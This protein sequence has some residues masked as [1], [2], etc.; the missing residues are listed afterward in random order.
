LELAEDPFRSSPLW[1]GDH[2]RRWLA[3]VALSAAIQA[4]ELSAEEQQ[5]LRDYD[6]GEI[7]YAKERGG[8]RPIT[9]RGL[10]REIVDLLFPNLFRSADFRA[11]D[12]P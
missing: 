4:R 8:M 5:A 2:F 3:E 11:P 10:F 1:Y 6:A 9:E 7:A 12:Q